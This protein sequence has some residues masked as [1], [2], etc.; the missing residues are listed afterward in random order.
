MNSPF[1]EILLALV[2]LFAIVWL[3]TSR[4][5]VPSK[6]I[7]GP[8][9]SLL[10][11]LL[12]IA[13]FIIVFL[14]RFQTGLLGL[15][16]IPASLGIQLGGVFISVIGAGFAIWARLIL[17]TN[18]SAKV[19]I[20]EGQRLVQNGP[21]AIVRNPIYTGVLFFMIGAALV[22]GEV[23]GLLG[24]GLVLIYVW[25]KGMTEERFLSQEFGEEYHEYQKRVK[26]MIPF[27]I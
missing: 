21:Y 23:R 26:F 22:S 7:E 20:K 14:N 15:R 27:I 3:I 25:H 1:R 24:L 10:H 13:G 16:L 17:G 12:L 18:W 19:A 8:A 2:L 11:S 4:N 6:K 9:S 5:T